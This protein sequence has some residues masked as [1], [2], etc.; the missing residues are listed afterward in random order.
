MTCRDLHDKL[1][2][3][4][5]KLQQYN[6]VV[7]HKRGC[8]HRIVDALTRAEIAPIHCLLHATHALP[9]DLE[10]DDDHLATTMSP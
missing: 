8:L 9:N 3:W 5:L 7:V 4:S 10:S 2:R 1:A 6:M